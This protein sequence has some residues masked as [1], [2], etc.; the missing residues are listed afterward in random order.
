MHAVTPICTTRESG[1]EGLVIASPNKFPA[2]SGLTSVEAGRRL[3]RYGPNDPAVVRRRSA[4]FQF[5]R[6]FA[7]PLILML[8]IAA[9]VSVVLGEVVSGAIII[10]MVLLSVLLNFAQ[11]FRSQRAAERLRDQVALT[12]SVLRDGNW[13]EIARRELVPG[14]L[15]RLIAGDL[16]PADGRLVHAANLHTQEA[17][18]TGESLP[19]EKQ[20]SCDEGEN[21]NR[22]FWALQS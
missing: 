12:A 9:F 7:N 14:D 1:N 4:V 6:L 15:I 11:S 19:V 13:V 2:E 10:V 18:L 3:T 22:V 8:I 16:I 17:A 21:L 5:L 20:P